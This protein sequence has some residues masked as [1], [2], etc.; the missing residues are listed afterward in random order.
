MPVLRSNTHFA[1][2][3][4]AQARA[5]L[6]DAGV[7][8]EPD[9][10]LM[11]PARAETADLLM[12][13]SDQILEPYSGLNT[14][15][16]IAARKDEKKL[17]EIKSQIER[18][19]KISPSEFDPQTFFEGG[20]VDMDKLLD[21]GKRIS[22]NVT[23]LLATQLRQAGNLD[24]YAVVPR[25]FN[26][27]DHEDDDGSSNRHEVMKIVLTSL[28]GPS[29]DVSWKQIV[30]YRSNPESFSRFQDLKDW[31]T[32]TAGGKL[33]PVEIREKLESLLDQYRRHL[34]IHQI[35]TVNATLEA[36]IVTTT[37]VLRN[38]ATVR[39]GKA[40]SMFSLQRRKLALLEEE[41]TSE[42]SVIAFAM[43]SEFFNCL[44]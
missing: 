20:P 35:N 31:M 32:D 1:T 12:R 22:T 37:N 24:A 10:N 2:K 29:D 9:E 6:I 8:F 13:D 43:Q 4:F 19:K 5:E 34:G 28:P 36:F 16:F 15:E 17:A 7:L 42:V 27:L 26:S 33:T 18:R 23:R 30:E 3:E 39:W 44:S 21:A 14:K 38:L 40:E 25:K 11:P 41:S